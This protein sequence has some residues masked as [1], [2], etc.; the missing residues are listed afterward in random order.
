MKLP[1]LRRNRT[2]VLPGVVGPVRVDRRTNNLTKRLRPG[3]LAVIDHAD[4]DR[5]NAEALV[6]SGVAVII[7]AAQSCTGSY[8]NLG[9]G[10]IA[11]S[12]IPLVDNVGE[13]VLAA[14]KDGERIRVDN[15]TLYRDTMP[16]AEGEVLD[17]RRVGELMEYAKDGLTTQ[18]EAFTANTTEYLRRERELLL[19]GV[20]VPEVTTRFQNRHALVVVQGYDYRRDLANL[21]SYIREYN[22]VLIGVED[23]ADSLIE[24]GYAPALI[25][26]DLSS[27]S[28][29]ALK[30]GAE[31]VVHS[32][33]DGR[34]DGFNRLERLGLHAV[35]FPATGTSEDIAML[36]ADERGADLIVA[37]GTH[38][39]LLEFLDKG[40]SGMSSAFLTRLRLGP[41]LIDAKGVAR[42]HHTRIRMR[43]LMLLLVAGLLAV[44]VSIFATPAGQE[45]FD[46][47]SGYSGDFTN[48]IQGLIS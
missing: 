31:L 35:P 14:L 17:S 30:S 12:G 34:A 20:G 16:I 39:S 42:L 28:D 33:R 23:G 27:V 25:V 3:D 40:K 19:D 46:G 11:D 15:G 7:N 6:D 36:L 47:L 26:G 18:L 10:I 45:W 29:A 43:H 4:I 21:K 22:P 41:K 2:D 32:Y 5:H 9:P 8:P 1:T 38:A 24:A 37:V 48:W 13:E 44:G